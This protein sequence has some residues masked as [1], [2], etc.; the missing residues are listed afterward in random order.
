VVDNKIIVTYLPQDVPARD[1]YH[2]YV[3]IY[4]PKTDVWSEGAES[5]FLL[6][7][8]GAGATTGVY[9]PKRVYV[10]GIMTASIFDALPTNRVYDPVGDTWASAEVMPTARTHFGM[11][12]VDDVLYIIG[13]ILDLSWENV[14]EKRP[15]PTGPN[16]ELIYIHYPSQPFVPTAVNEQYVPI[17]YSSTPLS[18]EPSTSKPF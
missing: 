13:G 7:S 4:D 5:E 1:L 15:T 14:P 10:L 6:C 17:G 9:A 18:S 8:G 2:T 12:I 11:A 3:M 16:G